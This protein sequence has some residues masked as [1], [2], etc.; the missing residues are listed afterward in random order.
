MKA[1]INRTYFADATLGFFSVDGVTDPVFATIERPWLDNKN[2]VSCIPEGVYRVKPFSSH[3][4]PNVWE[5]CD[6]TKRSGVLIHSANWVDQLKG[7]IAPGLS[8]GYMLRDGV[9]K[10]AVTNSGLA[11]NQMKIL[12]KYPAE[13]QLTIRS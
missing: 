10:K 11:I 4:N 8:S 2:F 6:V 9:N 1:T 12:L 5:I 13:F 3:D 7:C